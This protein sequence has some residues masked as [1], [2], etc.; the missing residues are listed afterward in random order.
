MRVEPFYNVLSGAAGE[1]DA[2]SEQDKR[3]QNLADTAI[4]S[5]KQQQ[6]IIIRNSRQTRETFELQL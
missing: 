3:K 5:D 4:T 1:S 6:I 2:V